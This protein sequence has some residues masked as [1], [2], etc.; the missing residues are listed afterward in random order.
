MYGYV[1][2]YVYVYA[3]VYVYV[4]SYVYLYIYV[5][6]AVG[7]GCSL[8]NRWSGALCEFVCVCVHFLPFPH[9]CMSMCA[10]VTVH[11]LL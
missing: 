10:W 9:A 7:V 11:I 8:V 6:D 4:H 3:C 1:F 2:V 5:C